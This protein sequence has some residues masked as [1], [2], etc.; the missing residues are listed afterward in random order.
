[1][2]A[3]LMLGVNPNAEREENDF[4]ATD[5][6]VVIKSK[7]FFEDIG[8][9]KNIWECA[10]GLGH[11]SKPLIDLGYE[12]Y[13]SDLIDR[14]Y[15]EVKDFLNCKETWNGDILTNPPFKLAPQFIR[16]AINIIQTN[17]LAVF[18]LKVQ[19]LETLERAKLFKECGLKYVGVHSERICCAKNGEF[20]Q[21]FK[22]GKNGAYRGGTQLYCWFV[23]QKGYQNEPIIK[24]I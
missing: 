4:Y 7:Q 13:S 9:N 18:L 14:N 6:Y 11:L 8:L 24:F 12:V 22:K 15:G 3:G 5:P 19:F 1:M 16:H 2:K 23:F 17:S 10:C 20:D 21:Y